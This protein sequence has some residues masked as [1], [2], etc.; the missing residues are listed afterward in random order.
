MRRK[1][2]GLEASLAF[3]GVWGLPYMLNLKGNGLAVSN[4]WFGVFVWGVLWF[5]IHKA[6]EGIKAR[7]RRGTGAACVLGFCFSLALVFGV[8]L[9]RAQSVDFGNGKMWLSA[10]VWTVIFTLWICKC[11]EYIE[12]QAETGGFFSE[13]GKNKGSGRAEEEAGAGKCRSWKKRINRWTERW[14][15]L[16]GT[17]RAVIMICFFLLCWLPVFLAVYP[18]F[19]VYDAQDEFIQVQTR[20][21]TTH[22][23]LPHVLLLGGI[24]LAIHKLTGSY[25]AGIAVYTLLQMCLMAGVFAFVLSYMRKCKVKRLF[26]VITALYFGFFPV[27]VMFVLCSAKDGIFTAALLLL[28]IAL[29]EMTKEGETFFKGW[30]KPFFFGISALVMMCFRH[31]GMYAFLVLS[32]FLL[33]YMKGCR[34]KL[35]ALLGITFAAYFLLSSGLA[36]FFSAGEPEKQEMLTVP[37]QQLARV[38]KYDKESLSQEELETLYEILPEKAFSFYA[39][40]V[41]DGVKIWFQND[42]F[43]QDPI[44]YGKLWLTTGLKHPLAYCNAWF[45]TSYGFWYPDT[46]IDVYRGNSVFTF[47]YEDSSFFGYEVEQPGIRQSKIPWLDAWYRKM[48]LEIAQQKI[49]VVSMLFSPGFLFWL[50]AFMAGYAYYRKEY[51]TL[52]PYAMIFLIWL[53]V[54]LGPTY[55]PRYVLILWFA[56]PV[57]AGELK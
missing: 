20:N 27:I 39:P 42:A 1:R 25:N 3:A 37:I 4:S 15:G 45:M 18:G 31:N 13:R 10:A 57:A 23:P 36:A 6:A 52:F 51:R 29:D 17:K 33:I 28:L 56:L 9:E 53:T 40:K 2:M 8:S 7:E 50:F 16:S 34:K 5:C 35:A 55:L 48:S 14:E 12:K 54:I 24:I 11:W 32:P 43:A 21:F 44:K 19:F 47:T 46:I 41:S 30:K 22:H 38:Y 26:R 49:P